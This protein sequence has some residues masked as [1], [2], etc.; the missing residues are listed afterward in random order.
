MTGDPSAKARALAGLQR[1]QA[2]IAAEIAALEAELADAAPVKGPA[3][4]PFA[5]DDRDTARNTI[6]RHARRR[7]LD[8]NTCADQRIE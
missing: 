3:V 5:P 6:A 7:I 4:S 8:R 1:K 2:G